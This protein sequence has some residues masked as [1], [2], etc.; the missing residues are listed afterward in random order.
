MRRKVHEMKPLRKQQ[1]LQFLRWEK[2]NACKSRDLNGDSKT[3][4]KDFH[5]VRNLLC[6]LLGGNREKHAEEVFCSCLS[7]IDAF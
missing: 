1:N 3:I 4:L 2:L 5:T 7:L 6:Q